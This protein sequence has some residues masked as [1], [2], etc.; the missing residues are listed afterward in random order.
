MLQK[1]TVKRI[2]HVSR[3][4]DWLGRAK[5]ENDAI[6]ADVITITHLRQRLSEEAAANEIL[7]DELAKAHLQIARDA[8]DVA[9]A[10][11]VKASKARYELKRGRG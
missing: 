10:L 2:N 6:T 8:P 4:F 9:Y 3:F 11:R 7:Q 5:A 1:R